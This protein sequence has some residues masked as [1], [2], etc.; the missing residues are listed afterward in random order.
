[1]N[2][3]ER[4]NILAELGI[5]LK[6][7]CN[8]INFEQIIES[9]HEQN[10]WFT[11]EFT[12]L[13][14]KSVAENYLEKEKLQKWVSK[15][16]FIENSSPKKIGLIM[17]GNIPLVGFHDL[18][19]VFISG[20]ISL[21][22]LSIKDKILI[23]FI[24]SLLKQINPE[25]AQYFE[26]TEKLEYFD[27]VIATG[28]DNSSRYFEYYFGKYPHIIR[29]NR[30]SV[31]VIHGN[32]SANEIEQLADDIFL[33]FG[34]GCRSVSKVYFPKDYKLDFFLKHIDKYS[35]F[36]DFFKYNNNYVYNKSIFLVNK[37]P[38]LDNGFLL[39]KEDESMASPL[40]TL[41]YEYYLS[42]NDLEQK[43]KFSMDKIQVI[44]SNIKLS[45]PTISFGQSQFPSLESY[46]DN[47]DTLE[48]LTNLKFTLE[49]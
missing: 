20:N 15:Y 39:L 35:H 8:D 22:K 37:E 23:P 40:S 3:N 32:E 9:T 14:I 42:N 19:S 34:L 11:P 17:A 45:F 29:K 46:S 2:L 6:K 26:I 16:K 4:I 38:H 27:A 7:G 31:A 10:R 13:A 30:N 12:R 44:V 49:K 25:T 1:M 18:L 47:I 33:Y 48:F 21:I 24:I 43:L 5:Q 36:N 41:H 28:S